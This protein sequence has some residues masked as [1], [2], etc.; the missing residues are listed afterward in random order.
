MGFLSLGL[1]EKLG[2]WFPVQNSL[3]PS[4]SYSNWDTW[5][6]AKKRYSE[7]NVSLLKNEVLFTLVIQVFLLWGGAALRP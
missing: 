3:H 5:K 6:L 4:P 2:V 7:E 1:T